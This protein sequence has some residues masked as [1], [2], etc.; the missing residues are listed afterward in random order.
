MS[1]ALALKALGVATAAKPKRDWAAAA[2]IGFA[3]NWLA[4]VKRKLAA[5]QNATILVWGDSTTRNSVPADGTPRRYPAQ[6]ADSLI[7]SGR[8]PATHGVRIYV[9]DSLSTQK[10]VLAETLR[11]PGNGLWLDIYQASVSG[12]IPR[13]FLHAYF[14]RAIAAVPADAL[15]IG[16][17]INLA[18]FTNIEGEMLAAIEQFR[19]VHPMT[20]ILWTTQHPLQANTNGETSWRPA[21]LRNAAAWGIAVDDTVYQAYL[22]AGKPNGLYNGDGIHESTDTGCALYVAMLNAW[23]DASSPGAGIARSPSLLLPADQQMIVNGDFQTWTNTAAAPDS[24]TS[25]GTIAFSKDT[26]T[27]ANPRKPFSLKGVASGAAQTWIDQVVDATKFRQYLLGKPVTACARVWRDTG[28][29]S[30]NLA[31]LCLRATAASLGGTVNAVIADAN[32]VQTNGFGWIVLKPFVLPDDITGLSLRLFIDSGTTPDGTKAC[33]VDQMS[34]VPG[35]M[36]RP[37]AA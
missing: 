16:H 9:Y 23:W 15:F 30:T 12:S 7:A 32:I 21:L 14:L 24:F 27:Y 29:S 1:A 28:G 4:S 18:S 11:D 8:L 10:Y 5:G 37:Y 25:S 31:R 3:A 13:Y 17:G 2:G 6:W 35:V 26:T 22:A 36:P 33:Y 34:L 19:T 20:P